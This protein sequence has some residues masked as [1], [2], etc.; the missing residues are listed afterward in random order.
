MATLMDGLTGAGFR[1][2]DALAAAA[3]RLAQS[4][5][6]VRDASPA[7][8]ARGPT[9][10]GSGVVWSPDGTIVTNA[11]VV[12][13]ARRMTV[14]L[15]DGR[16]LDAEVTRVDRRRDLAALKVD[17]LHLPAARPGDSSALRVGQLVFA[18]G[19]PWGVRN[20]MTTG[21]V[22][23]VGGGGPGGGAGRWVQ[24]D[25]ALAPGN[26][27]GPLADAWGRVVGVNSMIVRGLALAVPSD[28]VARFL[29]APASGGRRSAI[30]VTAR[31]VA[32]R[33]PDGDDRLAFV[34]L[35]VAPG[36]AAERAGL[37]VGDLVVG[38]G[39]A[40]FATPGD[41]A[42]ALADAVDGGGT[43]ELDVSRGG[44]APVAVRVTPR[45]ADARAAA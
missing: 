26:S 41:L 1:I 34:I 45:A 22:H 7:D 40:A 14:E 5:V 15:T 24:A 33:A 29:A 3:E 2:R 38:A 21:I 18:L 10:A 30:G 6:Q 32:V 16:A 11:H 13:G 23:A 42:G 12:R 20:T 27:G 8:V 43:L 9:G 4:T 25:V 31:A 37:Q 17:A 44:R 39:G 19:H 28:V 35:G 36:S